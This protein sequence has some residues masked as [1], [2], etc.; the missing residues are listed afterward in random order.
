MK[1]NIFGLL[2]MLSVLFGAEINFTAAVDRTQVGI[3]D[4]I[5]L[6]VSV[7]GQD[8]G[9]VPNPELPDL[10]DFDQLGSTSSQS[11]SISIINGRMS[12]QQTIS[13]IYFL[14][15][16]RT[17]TLTIGPCKL[18][19]KGQTYSTEPI[20]IQVEKGS[21]QKPPASGGQPRISPF[22]PPTQEAV[23]I[24][25]NLMLVASPDK[26]TVYKG[27]QVTVDFTLYTRLQLG[28]LSLDKLPNFS[29]FWVEK[30]YDAREL[31]FTERVIN[32]KRYSAC[33][34][35]KV[36]LFPM[37]AG[38]L[39]IEP[40]SLTGTVIRPARSFFDF[41][42]E[43]EPVKIQS[44]SIK[45]NVLPLP[46]TG[47]PVDFTGGVGEFNIKASLTPDSSV[48]GEPVNLTIKIS[49]T[50]NIKLIDKPN[51]PPITGIKILDPEVNDKTSIEGGRISGY[52]EF[53]YPLL[54]ER[55]GRHE[56]PSIKI[57][58]FDP[59]DKS[60][61]TIG[62]E[63]LVFTATGTQKIVSSPL[64]ET[65]IKVLGTDIHHIKPNLTLLKSQSDQTPL[66]L[67]IIYPLS[68][69]F[70][71]VAVFYRQHKNRLEKD[72]GYARRLRSGRMM[73][74]RFSEASKFLAQKNEKEFYAA[75]ARAIF[76]YV[77]DRF[78]IQA[79]AMTKEELKDELAKKG[80]SE[81]RVSQL[82]KIIETC[83]QARFAKAMVADVNCQNL[84]RET[85]E[86]LSR[87]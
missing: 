25:G 73:K 54:P 87:L 9:R 12:Q 56:V 80:L 61:H 7:S 52:K 49:G 86:L 66:W 53:K 72:V 10:T 78:N 4:Q 30:I 45:I 57:S 58:Y 33:L 81:D 1:R 34:L 62:T 39:T 29:G 42:D 35:K 85:K 14:R 28:N 43:T 17:G 65:G 11:T 36:A 31:N 23:P 40:M 38:E 41:F 44:Q 47:K 46:E 67:V 5:Q 16:K 74:K 2:L 13:F 22:Q 64:T 55:D 15:P 82:L 69:V 59:K 75:L 60:Y 21:V 27:E 51:L 48:N 71:L 24:E 32:G 20:T 8:I 50:G 18:N 83:E 19:F 37:Q 63:K 26:R 68:I 70:L 79:M 77:G 84:L 6:T 76:G 3:D